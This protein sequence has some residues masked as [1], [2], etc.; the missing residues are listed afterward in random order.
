MS[1]DIVGIAAVGLVALGGRAAVR[2]AL[3]YLI[4]AVLGSLFFLV[5]VG[6]IYG[7]TGTLDMALAGQRWAASGAPAALASVAVA[8]PTRPLSLPSWAWAG[9]PTL[10]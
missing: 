3:R 9:A 8:P 1:M 7:T 4:V 10:R 2:A 5:A 6:I